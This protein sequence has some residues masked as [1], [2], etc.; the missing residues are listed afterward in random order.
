VELADP[1]SGRPAGKLA[2]TVQADALR[3]GL[4]LEVG[5]RDDCVVR[6]LPPLDVSAEV[7]DTACSILITAIHE[8]CPTT[9]RPRPGPLT[10]GEARLRWESTSVN[11]VAANRTGL[12]WK[13]KRALMGERERPG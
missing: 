2:R 7:V 1:L 4:I 5:G 6:M 9:W 13:G 11:A 8:S 10:P 12:A 3:R